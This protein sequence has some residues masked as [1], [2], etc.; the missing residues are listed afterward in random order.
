MGQPR[1]TI[2]NPELANTYRTIA[3]E[4]VDAFYKGSIAREMVNYVQ[5]N[6]GLWTMEDLANYRTIW[7]EPLSM[8]YR[9][10]TVYG[11]PPPSSAVTWMEMLKIAAGLRLVQDAR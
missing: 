10:L 1:N 8:K 2:K 5:K 9:N 4:G 6:N 3:K 7:T 11:A